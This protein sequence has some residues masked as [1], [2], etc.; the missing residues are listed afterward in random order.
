[1]CFCLSKG[2]AAPAGSLLVGPADFIARSLSLRKMLG[3]APGLP[4][5]SSARTAAA[6]HCTSAEPGVRRR[7]A[8]AHVGNGPLILPFPRLARARA[9]LWQAACV[10]LASSL[11][12]ASSRCSRRRRC[13]RW[14]TRTRG[15]LPRVSRPRHSCCR[16]RHCASYRHFAHSCRPRQMCTIS[17]HALVHGD[18]RHCELAL[19]P[20]LGVP[21]PLYHVCPGFST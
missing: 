7:C 18:G 1:M 14:T 11:R 20:E 4:S 8:V 21:L 6:S 16:S 2:L 19:R 15:C 10:R 13:C 17:A 3:G 5:D 9:C 12:R